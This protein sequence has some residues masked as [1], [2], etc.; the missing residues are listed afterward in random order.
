MLDIPEGTKA[1]EKVTVEESEV[2][3]EE[4]TEFKEAK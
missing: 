1:E 2:V 4:S 3:K